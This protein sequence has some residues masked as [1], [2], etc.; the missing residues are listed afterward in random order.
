[1]LSLLKGHRLHSRVF[2]HGLVVLFAVA[3]TF[4]LLFALL[5]RP[6]LERDA[7]VLSK[8]LGPHLCQALLNPPT[9]DRREDAVA[10]PSYLAASSYSDRGV[11][12]RSFAKPPLPPLT[13]EQLMLLRGGGQPLSKIGFSQAV[14]CADGVGG[15]YIVF[16]PSAVPSLPQLAPPFIIVIV[17]VAFASLPFARSITRPIE[18]VVAITQAFGRGDL[19]ARAETAR[20]D[21]VGDLARAFNDMAERVERLIRAE[22]ELLANVSHEL[23]TPLARIRVVLETAIENPKRVPLLLAEIGTDLTDLERLVESVMEAMRL[24]MGTGALSGGQ[25]PARLEATDIRGLVLDAVARFRDA[26]G[27]RRVVIEA[28]EEVTE[29]HADAR[30]VRRLLYNLLENACKYSEADSPIRVRIG[31]D[32]GVVFVKVADSGIGIEPQD[33]PHV[34]EPF[35]RS[36]RSRTRAT[37]GT[38]LG[39]A[40]VKRIADVHGGHVAIQSQPGRGTTVSFELRRSP[41][42]G[43]TLLR[44]DAPEP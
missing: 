14:S 11:L 19:S 20:R 27:E 12:R 4:T 24:E 23:R 36:D 2:L 21:E 30:L 29:A 34:F 17:F 5:I 43:A 44:G 16:Q 40:L 10:D 18:R 31:G 8:W 22:Q 7:L 37:G 3:L 32:P 33:L 38:G 9:L 15:G 42:V 1:M 6:G 26:H 39:L 28:T 25:L 35:F 13:P 41:P